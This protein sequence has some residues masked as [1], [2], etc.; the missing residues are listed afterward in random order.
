MIGLIISLFMGLY[1]SPQIRELILHSTY[2]FHHSC[3]P[4]DQLWT[5]NG[6]FTGYIVSMTDDGNYLYVGSI[7]NGIFRFENPWQKRSG[8]IEYETI[9]AIYGRAPDTL[10]AGTDGSGLW[11]TING[12]LNWIQNNMV[13]DTAVINT[14][15]RFNNSLYFLGTNGSGI[16]RSTDG[17]ASWNKSGNLPDMLNFTSFARD[18]NTPPRIFLGTE[19]TGIYVSIDQGITWSDYSEPEMD[20]EKLRFFVVNADSYLYAGCRGGLYYQYGATWHQ[21]VL[22]GI[23]VSDIQRKGDSILVATWGNGIFISG[24]GDSI[25]Y[26]RNQGLGYLVV[27]CLNVV[28]DTIFAGTCGGIYYSTN[29]G[30]NWI[31]FN[32]NINAALIYDLTINPQNQYSVYALS[33]GAGLFKSSNGGNTWFH[34][35]NPPGLPFLTAMA[36]NPQDSAHILIGSIFGMFITTDNGFTWTTAN[37]GAQLIT[38][39]EFDP[40]NPFIAYAGSNYMFMRTTD[41]G[42]N[43]DT[44]NFGNS[45]NDIKICPQAPETIYVATNKGVFKSNNYGNNLY[46]SGLTDT[47]IVS[48]NID[49]YFSS[50]L[51][52]GLEWPQSGQPGIYKSTDGGQTW[53]STHFP[54]I[55]C[56]GIQTIFDV[57]FYLLACSDQSSCYLSLDAGNNWFGLGP[58]IPGNLSPVIGLSQLQHTLYLG[59]LAGVYAYTDSNPPAVSISA[60]DSFSPDGDLIDDNI[61]FAL[62]A[63]DTHGILYW[64]LKIIKDSIV[65]LNKEGFA[66]PPD[67]ISWNGFDSSDVLVRNGSYIAGFFAYDGFFNIDTASKNIFVAKKPLISGVGEATSLPSGRKIAVD[68]TGCIHIVYTTFK[69]EEIFY[70][71]S[72]DGINWSEPLDL[73]NSPSESSK[74]PCIVINSNNTIYIFWEE[75]YADSQEICYQ[76]YNGQWFPNPRRLT[77]TA[78]PSVNPSVVVTSNNDLHLVWEEKAVS[79]IFYRHYNFATGFWDSS[80]NVSGTAGLSRDPFIMV[81]NGLYVFFADRTNQSNFD[82]RY[83]HGDGQNWQPVVQ[84]DTTPGDSYLPVAVSDAYNRIHLCWSDSTPGNIDIFY[85]CLTPDSG[86]SLTINLTQTPETSHFPTLTIDNLQNIYLYW[87]ED[88][89]IYQRVLDHQLGWLQYKNI[90]NSSVYSRYPSSALKTDLVWTENDSTPFNI[91]YYKEEILDTTNPNF[92]ISAP[93]TTYLNDSLIIHLSVDEQLQA[94][95]IAYLKDVQNDSI[96]FNVT[97]DSTFNYS[98]RLLVSGLVS[99]DGSIS[100]RGQD[101]SGNQGVQT[102][103]IFIDT[104]DTIP[105]NFTI[106]APD[107]AYINDTLFF[108][109]IA[110]E[111]L[112]S[113]PE[114]WLK[115]IQQD[116]VHLSVTETSPLHYAGQGYITNLVLGAGTLFVSGTDLHNNYGEDNKQ[117]FI[118]SLDSLSPNFSLSYP[119][120]FFIGDN[121]IVVITPNEPLMQEPSVWLYDSTNDSLQLTVIS[122]SNFYQAGDTIVGLELGSGRLRVYGVDLSGNETDTTVTIWIDARGNLLPRDSCFAFPN[123]THKDYIKFM[124]YLNQ[125]G[126]LKIEIF[127]LSGRRIGTFI[128]DD[129][130]GGRIYERQM[131]VNEMGTDIY[132]FRAHAN[133][134]N[135][136]ATVMKKF[137]V[138]R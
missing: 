133:A 119:D 13:P 79:E 34:Y 52:A 23:S 47:S 53:T 74:N 89:D 127:T 104:L 21:T 56:F 71:Y 7:S 25:L 132:I 37:T 73:S 107:T 92:T 16:Y 12:G 17:G 136:E 105:P 11:T 54:D 124:F 88:K 102:K 116:T 26:P 28:G 48:I 108:T 138:I 6:P 40:T 45:Y 72:P 19:S 35:G 1:P 106:T 67:T 49:G 118:S 59:N 131:S 70:T 98:G 62:S 5:A 110:S 43:W 84:V 42:L 90:S 24:I 101:L 4:G 87:Q 22:T 134:G 103:P 38:D 69:P 77:Q 61:E 125:N 75:Q 46:P 76:R 82:I 113:L 99:G 10:L 121:P 100:V 86:W 111:P 50:L 126:H 114:A 130:E 31:E 112:T 27:N 122:D 9:N 91:I 128:D 109:F 63:S 137:G 18:F 120:T 66:L 20:I 55:P 33:F 65:L 51:Y 68:D 8:N 97:L 123:P 93:E 15:F 64:N 83:R 30:I 80:I 129:F 81:H 117:I 29:N 60:P 2:R 94:L 135:H 58:D 78:G 115:D 96:P 95:P 57:P 41:G 39:I 14:F 36:V 44:L 32:Q 85:K 3:D